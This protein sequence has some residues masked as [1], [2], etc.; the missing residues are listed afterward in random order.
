MNNEEVLSIGTTTSRIFIDYIKNAKDSFSYFCHK[1]EGKDDTFAINS[2]IVHPTYQSLC[3]G[4]SDA[5]VLFWNLEKRRRISCIKLKSS[6]SSICFTEDGKQLA[7][8]CSHNTD[9][10]IK[11]S[12]ALN[13]HKI[14]IR[15]VEESQLKLK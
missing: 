8:A 14:I 6:V 15:N 3:T 1:I 10:G 11:D 4:G 13:A 12:E 5:S 7:M 9:N 2:L